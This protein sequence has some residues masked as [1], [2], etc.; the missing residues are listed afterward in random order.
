MASEYLKWKYRDEKPRE[1]KELTKE[2]KRANWWY[3]HKYHVIFGVIGALLLGDLI[4][5]ATGIFE[6]KPD[7]QIALITHSV[8]DSEMTARLKNEME[9]IAEDYNGDRKVSVAVNSYYFPESSG[10]EETMYA[11]Y[12]SEVTLISDMEE[13]SSFVFLMPEPD[14][15]Q[16]F[17]EILSFT[18]GSLP[19][20]FENAEGCVLKCSDLDAFRNLP[21]LADW[22]AGR[23]GFWRSK[24][25]KNIKGC[26]SFWNR[27][28]QEK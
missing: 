12:A 16:N 18:D 20:T 9:Q 23:R 17:F 14:S 7:V 8:P 5:D 26:E 4:I 24:T 15:F 28:I 2:E 11:G 19:E 1:K 27:L 10:T 22:Y 25:V 3:Y 13:C 21:E 6:T